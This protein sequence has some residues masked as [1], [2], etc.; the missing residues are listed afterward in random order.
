MT[1]FAA[2]SIPSRREEKVEGE[3]SGV[4]TARGGM[5]YDRNMGVIEDKPE[6]TETV[7]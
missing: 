2:D 5:K 1:A 4:E 7:K 3:R 6:E